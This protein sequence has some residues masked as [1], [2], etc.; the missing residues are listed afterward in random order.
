M[1]SLYCGLDWSSSAGA[2]KRPLFLLV[3]CVRITGSSSSSSSKGRGVSLARWV[4]PRARGC[5][6]ACRPALRA[7][8]AGVQCRPAAGSTLLIG[9]GRDECARMACKRGRRTVRAQCA[10]GLWQPPGRRPRGRSDARAAWWWCWRAGRVVVSAQ[11]ACG[12]G[13]AYLFSSGSDTAGCESRH[14]RMSD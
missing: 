13:L 9:R 4:Q 2:P 8:G 5:A 7:A 11:C 10:G 1:R 6:Q 14:K 12:H 3:C